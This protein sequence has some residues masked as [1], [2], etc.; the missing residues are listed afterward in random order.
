MPWQ[1]SR[2][3]PQPISRTLCPHRTASSGALAVVSA[4]PSCRR[5]CAP[6]MPNGSMWWRSRDSSRS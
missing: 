4:R 1:K 6:T 5:R 2:S 3:G